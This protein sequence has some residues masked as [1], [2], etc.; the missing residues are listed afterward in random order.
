MKSMGTPRNVKSYYPP[1]KQTAP[2]PRTVRATGE[3]P[4]KPVIRPDVT[5]GKLPAFLEALKSAPG[6]KGQAAPAFKEKVA[7]AVKV[8][9]QYP[10]KGPAIPT[11][12]QYKMWLSQ[13]KHIKTVGPEHTVAY[14]VTFKK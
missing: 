3:K 8:A 4:I 9:Q 11:W 5:E 13:M 6:V 10:G 7:Q 1:D 2:P 14:G 12:R